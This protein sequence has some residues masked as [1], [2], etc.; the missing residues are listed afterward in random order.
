MAQIT[1][2]RALAGA[3]LAVVGVAGVAV[4]STQALAAGGDKLQEK[5]QAHFPNSKITGVRCG[6]TAAPKGLCEVTIGSNVLYVT[7]DAQFA[8]VG[9]VLDLENKIDLTDRRMRELA[10]VANVTDKL[11]GAAPSLPT[12]QAPAPG[13]SAAAPPPQQGPGAPPAKVNVSLPKDN[14]IIHNPGAPVKMTVFTDL[15]CSY[16]NKLMAELK[17]VTDIE[18]TEF[19]IGILGP[20]SEQKAKMALCATDRVAATNALYFG[21]EVKVTGECEDAAKKVQQN[22]QFAQ[23]NG[24]SGT[25]AVIRADG[26]MNPGYMP[27]AELRAF[28]QGA[29]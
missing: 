23:A 11:G 17:G 5:V 2:K 24:I 26:A 4:V 27:L 16:C 29:G 14:A 15:N 6:G 10:A 28:L 8:I 7:P 20:E 9:S 25:P 21:G 18:I 22:N 12:A 19:P 13:P 3:A 1:R